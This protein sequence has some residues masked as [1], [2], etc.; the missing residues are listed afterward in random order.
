VAAAVAPAAGAPPR[1]AHDIIAT[2]A[3]HRFRSIGVRAAA[4]AQQAKTA[5]DRQKNKKNKIRKRNRN[6]NKSTEKEK[7]RIASVDY[8][9]DIII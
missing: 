6:D 7:K 5:R 8:H 1:P 2:H 9:Y 4:L 3:Q